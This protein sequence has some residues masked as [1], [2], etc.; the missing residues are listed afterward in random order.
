MGSYSKNSLPFEG[1]KVY[2]PQMALSITGHSSD[3]DP[4]IDPCGAFNFIGPLD[5]I[6]DLG[7]TWNCSWIEKAAPGEA[8]EILV[9]PARDPSAHRLVGTGI[10]T[11][12]GDSLMVSFTTPDGE[13][14]S[15]SLDYQELLHTISLLKAGST[16]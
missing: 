5:Y 11:P 10:R 3:S 6:L 13:R 1:I 15:Y 14:G 2:S 9:Y 7:H 12:N 16:L 8:I 4:T